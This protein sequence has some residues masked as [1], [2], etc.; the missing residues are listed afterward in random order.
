MRIKGRQ[1]LTVLGVRAHIGEPERVARLSGAW[2]PP[3][4][5]ATGFLLAGDPPESCVRPV[6]S[7]SIVLHGS[8]VFFLATCRLPV[9]DEL[10]TDLRRR[11]CVDVSHGHEV[12]HAS[13]YLSLEYAYRL[14]DVRDALRVGDVKR[15]SRLAS[16]V[17]RLT[18][19]SS[20][21]LPPFRWR[22]EVARPLRSLASARPFSR[23]PQYS[24]LSQRDALRGCDVCGPRAGADRANAANVGR[25]RSAGSRPRRYRARRE[26]DRSVS[27]D[28][29]AR[30]ARVGVGRSTRP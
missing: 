4:S 15:A 9:C 17:Y 5:A 28:D 29:P 2:K 7:R 20:S 21:S 13:P 10:A 23:W 30:P 19:Y 12:R 3:R 6:T 18:P 14:D 8:F 26:G 24:S 16:R 11:V 27:L 25:Y 1:Q 22:G